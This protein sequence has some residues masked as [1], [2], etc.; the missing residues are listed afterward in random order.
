MAPH[1][2]Y[3]MFHN[4]LI[5]KVKHIFHLLIFSSFQF[6]GQSDKFELGVVGGPS[7]ASIYGNNALKQYHSPSIRFTFGLSF[8]YNFP[9]L[10]SI[11]SGIQYEKKG[12]EF[13]S[14]LNYTD[15]SGNVIETEKYSASLDFNYLTVPVFCRFNFGKKTKFHLG[16]G[17][18]GGYLISQFTEEDATKYTPKRRIEYTNQFHAL[19]WGLIGGLG[20]SIPIK[21]RITGLAEIRNNFG[22]YNI[23]A[24]PVVNNGAIKT[25]SLNFILGISIKLIKNQ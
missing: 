6:F 17:I 1:P 24:V 2:P 20:V 10:F 23:S 14:V 21:S 16:A 7:I 25:N 15:I 22:L 12:S 13:N 4:Q 5:L 19:D 8:H 18:F 3:L 11:H 9:K